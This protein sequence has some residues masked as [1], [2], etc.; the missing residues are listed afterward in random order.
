MSK[1]KKIYTNKRIIVLLVFILLSIIL[2]N[3]ATNS[4]GVAIRS[5]LPGSAAAEAYPQ[6][7]TNPANTVKPRGREVIIAVSDKPIN[8]VQEYYDAIKDL[9]LN[10]T[11]TIQTTKQKYFL[12]I[13]PIY[14]KIET[15]KTE[16]VLVNRT[17]YV[18]ETNESITKEVEIEQPI[19]EEKIIGTQDV[20]ITVYE[21]PTTNIKK[22]LDLEGGTRVL[23]KPQEEVNDD[24]MDIV[25]ENI[26]QRLNVFG[27]SDITVRPTRDFFGNQFISVE[28]AGANEDQVKNLLTEQGEFEAKIGEKTVFIGGNKDILNV[29]RTN[30]CSY[31]ESA[32]TCQ[33]DS[34]GITRCGFWFTITLSQEAAN[35]QADAT[36]DL[37]IIGSA[38]GG[39][40]TENLTLVLDKEIV[41][42]LSISAGLK[43]L[44]STQI[45][46][47]GS[48][49]GQS[50]T[51][52]HEDALESMKKLQTLL[53]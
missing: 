13:N 8:T 31:I 35:R 18:N 36:R 30:Q 49:E 41:D 4:D 2:I 43:G 21:K 1:L 29:C 48:G 44:A 24:D 47:T 26:K 38:S 40:L 32:N 34:T 7:I 27:V 42:Q 50:T 17:T 45:R 37:G 12:T 3:P 6:A 46:I 15:N 53:I 25:V 19:Y 5:V 20:G 16:T 23:L 11:F 52:A 22:G 28:I 33:T 39:Y 9:K 51:G 14:E 10:D